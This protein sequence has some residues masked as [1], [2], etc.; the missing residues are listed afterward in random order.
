MATPTLS[1]L[2]GTGYNQVNIPRKTPDQMKLF[3]QLFQSAGGGMGNILSQLQGLAGGGNEEMWQQ[4]EAPAMRQFQNLQGNTASRFSGMGM[5]ARNSSGFQ[6]EMGGQAADLAERLRGQRMGLQMGAQNQLMDLYKSL[7]GEDF[8]D[9]QLMPEQKPAW[10]QFLMGMG[11]GLGSGLGGFGQ[12]GLLMKLFPQ[13][14]NLGSQ[15]KG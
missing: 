2:S 4:L 12:M 15:T 9:T 7:M 14:F 13:A 6:N 8:F 3:S 10:Q 1:R 5:G 11:P